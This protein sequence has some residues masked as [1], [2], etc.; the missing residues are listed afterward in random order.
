LILRTLQKIKNDKS[1]G[2]VI[3]PLWKSQ[4]WFPVYMKMLVTKP[5]IFTPHENL[6]SFGCRP[7]PLS[8]SLSLMAGVLSGKPI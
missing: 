8:Q 6:L 1:I 3:V 5:L 7:H 2:V 4:P